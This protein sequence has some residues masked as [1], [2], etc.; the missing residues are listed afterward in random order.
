MVLRG[1]PGRVTVVIGLML[2]AAVAWAQ[3]GAT[4][5]GSI[6]MLRGVFGGDLLSLVT[7]V[8]DGDSFMGSTLGQM[9]V[10]I[11]I[12][13]ASIAGLMVAYTVGSALVQTAQE[14]KFMGRRY[15]SFWVVVRTLYGTLLIVPLPSGLCLVQVIVLWLAVMGC[16][17][18]N[19]V[20]T[21][22]RDLLVGQAMFSPERLTLPPSHKDGL[23]GIE[24]S[25]LELTLGIRA[26]TL[27]NDAIKRAQADYNARVAY[28]ND[29]NQTGL[30]AQN[31]DEGLWYLTARRTDEGV[32]VRIDGMPGSGQG[33]NAAQGVI[34]PWVAG[35]AEY[36]SLRDQQY[37]AIVEATKTLSI[38]SEQAEQVADP[39]DRDARNAFRKDVKTAAE[40]YAAALDRISAV[41]YEAAIAQAKTAFNS[42][43]LLGANVAVR[44]WLPISGGGQ[45]TDWTGLG[46]VYFGGVATIQKARRA[47]ET[48]NT[49][50]VDSILRDFQSLP[51]GA[52]NPLVTG[53]AALEFVLSGS[54]LVKDLATD[55]VL[56][57]YFK[58]MKNLLDDFRLDGVSAMAQL[59]AAGQRIVSWVVS[60]WMMFSVLMGMIQGLGQL[61]GNL[62]NQPIVGI[63]PAVIGGALSGILAGVQML[64]GWISVGM[65]TLLLAGVGFMI[66]LPLVPWIA[67]LG[68]IIGWL[69][70]VAESVMGCVPWAA[71]HLA[72]EG[73]GLSTNRTDQ[74]YFWLMALLLRPAFIVMAFHF[75]AAIF[76]IVAR[77][78]NATFDTFFQLVDPTSWTMVFGMIAILV[79]YFALLVVIVHKCF[80]G[81]HTVVD[82]ALQWVGASAPH[83]DM[84]SRLNTII[85]GRGM[86]WLERG[87]RGG[88]GGG[89]GGSRPP[90]PPRGNRESPTPSNDGG[91]GGGRGVPVQGASPAPQRSW[92]PGGGGRGRPGSGEGGPR[93]ATTGGGVGS[94]V[95]GANRAG[96]SGAGG[97]EGGH[98]SARRSPRGPGEEQNGRG[99][100]S[101]GRGPQGASAAATKNERRGGEAQDGEAQDNEGGGGAGVE[102]RPKSKAREIQGTNSPRRGK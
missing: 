58:R 26:A 3:S 61:A 74:G 84:E 9:L 2:A 70:V 63:V 73:E 89:G 96:G 28:E 78:A 75:V 93:Q 76:E 80:E 81:M 69:L 22:S 4:P 38:A 65:Q 82:R 18:A 72:P 17:V 56:L 48:R 14:G 10:R 7:G 45:V 54:R 41:G 59:Q 95:Q 20:F 6:D 62:S 102:T 86:S 47:M 33:Q 52:A 15:N 34:F 35:G 36:A 21:A 51:G 11:N 25:F 27:H 24:T 31:G 5:P 37:L 30:N 44:P 32:E 43:Q 90:R 94:G 85:M 12:V 13:V 1:A 57:T 16:N 19:G 64:W 23:A 91:G 39:E 68:A 50:R 83:A 67:W 99:R 98:D 40:T 55:G 77:F 29:V 42:G 87:G 66:Y 88:G 60:I 97:A 101:A 71:M 53:A 92:Q 79:A 100:S 49:D 46:G 8:S